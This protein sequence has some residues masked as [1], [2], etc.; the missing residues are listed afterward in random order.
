MCSDIN[1]RKIAIYLLFSILCSDCVF[2]LRITSVI[3]Q[4]DDGDKVIYHG[5]EN[6]PILDYHLTTTKQYQRE[7][8]A[9]PTT[10]TYPV[11]YANN[12]YEEDLFTSMRQRHEENDS[13]YRQ[14]VNSPLP[15]I[16]HLTTTKQYTE[17]GTTN[18]PVQYAKNNFSD[19]RFSCIFL[20]TMYTVLVAVMVSIYKFCVE[21]SE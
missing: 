7:D 10:T 17:E 1:Y 18:T 16:F 3:R 19:A 2:S 5:D 12:S 9:N 15:H 11:E 14:N 20:V 4:R 21:N 13:I 8:Q 6:R